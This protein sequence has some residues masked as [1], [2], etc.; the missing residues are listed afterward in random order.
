MLDFK[1]YP[2]MQQIKDK[3][4]EVTPFKTE[5]D[6]IN[7][8]VKQT[9][10]THGTISSYFRSTYDKLIKKTGSFVKDVEIHTGPFESFVI[11]QEKQIK[12]AINDWMKCLDD[13]KTK[14]HLTYIEENH[15]TFSSLLTNL[16]QVSLEIIYAISLFN[17]GNQDAA[18]NHIDN[19]VTTCE[20][21]KK[22]CSS[23]ALAK[24]LAYKLG[25]LTRC[26]ERR[27]IK[28]YDTHIQLLKFNRN[29]LKQVIANVKE[30]ET[31]YMC[32][33]NIA[34]SVEYEYTLRDRL[35]LVYDHT[36]KQTIKYFKMAVKH[37]DTLK[38]RTA[39]LLRLARAYYKAGNLKA[40]R[41]GYNEAF[42]LALETNQPD[43]ILLTCNDYLFGM[44]FVDKEYMKKNKILVHNLIETSQKNY[45]DTKNA[46]IKIQYVDTMYRINQDDCIYNLLDLVN[47]QNLMDI[48]YKKAN[49]L[50]QKIIQ[51]YTIEQLKVLKT[52]LNKY[53]L[54]F[55]GNSYINP[56]KQYYCDVDLLMTKR[57]DL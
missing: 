52:T 20:S 10:R 38:R 14:D 56:F 28:D 53:I 6:L 45:K 23:E 25:M 18:F 1:L 51:D 48:T 32:F 27:Q 36:Y 30:N 33:Y 47:S 29:K 15:K 2:E 7:Y 55:E 12:D 24:L 3:L 9:N 21:S 17:N 22:P 16:D 44:N 31:L 39:S 26:I 43:L 42:E 11:P 46:D 41:K 34:T 19:L 4:F 57:E 50:F 5:D 13:F 40:A 54:S 35:N 37:S 49:E 8:F